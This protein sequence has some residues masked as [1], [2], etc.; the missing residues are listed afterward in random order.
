MS[1]KKEIG[2]VVKTKQG[3]YVI[4][5][6][7]EMGTAYFVK[8]PVCGKDIDVF[9]TE[10]GRH[11]INCD[12]GA[13][14]VFVAKKSTFPKESPKEKMEKED[15]EEK[16]KKHLPTHK[17]GKL[18][19]NRRKG[20]FKWGTWPFKH[21][22]MLSDGC[23][24]IGRFDEDYPSDI[25]LKDSYVSRRSVEVEVNDLGAGYTFLLSVK[26]ATNQV[27]VNGREHGEGTS[28]YLNDGDVVT[29]GTTK[30]RFCLE[31]K[32]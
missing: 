5:A 7:V 16:E 28:V 8:C 31:D 32:K 26:K 2:P 24:T 19:K 1:N 20:S 27:Y 15:R 13:A 6:L 29:L 17:I 25:Q 3:I 9:D 12:C 22:Y 23:N 10:A 11:D 18:S 14:F 4:N 30:L 21:K